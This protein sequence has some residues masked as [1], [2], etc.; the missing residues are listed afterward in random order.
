[1]K[2]SKKLSVLAGTAGIWFLQQQGIDATEVVNQVIV[3]PIDSMVEQ[4]SHSSDK[5]IYYLSGIYIAIQGLVDTVTAWASKDE[6]KNTR[7]DE[8]PLPDSR[9]V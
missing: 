4:A 9:R 2:I 8:S 3:T 1:M 6:N 5:I 7:V